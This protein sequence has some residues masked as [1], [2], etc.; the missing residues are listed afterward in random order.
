MID[1]TVLRKFSH[2]IHK[3]FKPQLTMKINKKEVE[4]LMALTKDPNKPMRKY[5]RHLRLEKG[6][7]T[8]VVDLLEAKGLIERILDE[9]DK[10]KRT[11]SL[12]TKGN[13]IVEE[14]LVQHDVYIENRF[15][16]FNENEEKEL[17]AAIETIGRLFEKLP[18]VKHHRHHGGHR[19]K[20]EQCVKHG[21]KV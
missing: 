9:E 17:S 15:A 20:N 2:E 4:L 13:T 10:R 7:F 5:G 18:E 14:I 11:L 8:Y 21:S 12:T 19:H 6:S 16:V 1:V 3:G